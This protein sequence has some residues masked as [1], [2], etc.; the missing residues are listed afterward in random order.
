MAKNQFNNTFNHTGPGEVNIAIGSNVIAKK[1]TVVTSVQI[2]NT[3]GRKQKTTA[4]NVFT[5]TSNQSQDIAQGNGAM[6]SQINH[7]RNGRKLSVS[8]GTGD[9]EMSIKIDSKTVTL[10][11]FRQKVNDS[12]EKD[13]HRR[14]AENAFDCIEIHLEDDTPD[15]QL[16]ADRFKKIFDLMSNTNISFIEVRM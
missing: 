5:C 8:I 14:R 7:S 2:N 11:Q 15:E 4:Q 12:I 3:P 13:L 6:S 10:D 9:N 16:I 1:E